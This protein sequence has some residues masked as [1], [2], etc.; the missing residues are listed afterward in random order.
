MRDNQGTACPGKGRETLAGAQIRLFPRRVKSPCPPVGRPENSMLLPCLRQSFRL[1]CSCLPRQREVSPR[2]EVI[3]HA[4][5]QREHQGHC[6][7]CG[8]SPDRPAAF[9]RLD[10]LEKVRPR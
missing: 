4:A 6:R 2:E 5:Y 8:P 10:P 9:L 7:S 1:Q 3:A